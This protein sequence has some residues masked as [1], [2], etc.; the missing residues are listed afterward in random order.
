M[1]GAGEKQLEPQMRSVYV[2]LV[3]VRRAIYISVHTPVL[4]NPLW[5]M[6]ARMQLEERRSGSG[7]FTVFRSIYIERGISGYWSEVSAL[8]FA[9]SAL[10]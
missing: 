5:L 4:T 8:A 2:K 6:K 9:F 3:S 1:S 7:H 10:R